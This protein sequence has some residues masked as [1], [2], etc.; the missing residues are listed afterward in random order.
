ME[1]RVYLSL[2]SNI[3][4]REQQL[5]NAISQL[6]SLGR[7][8]ATSSIYETQPVDF[9]EQPWFLNCVIALETS[10]SP[11]DLMAEILK[12]EKEMGR[13]RTREKG[14]RPIDI[15][16][17]LFGDMVLNTPELIIPHPAM[18]NRRFVLEPLAEIAPQA[19]HPVLNATIREL[20]DRLSSGQIVRRVKASSTGE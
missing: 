17:L 8:T 4:D 10:K 3:G 16:I 20:L 14:P 2:G 7:V 19:L 13:R 11:A 9:T 6:G 5:H 1:N 12:I 18:A 15:D